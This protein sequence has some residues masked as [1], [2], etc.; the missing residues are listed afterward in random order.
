MKT[1]NDSGLHLLGVNAK[2]KK[3]PYQ[4]PVLRVY[5][6]VSQLT[7]GNSGTMADGGSQNPKNK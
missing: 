2:D 1:K 4:A 6:A 7:A 3:A 5:G